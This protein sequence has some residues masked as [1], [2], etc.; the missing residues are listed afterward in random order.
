MSVRR[1]GGR[2]EQF[3][4]PCCCQRFNDEKRSVENRPY[5]SGEHVKRP[6]PDQVIEIVSELGPNG[7]I[8]PIPEIVAK[9][10]QQTGCSRATAEMRRTI[11]TAP[12]LS[13]PRSVAYGAHDPQ[14]P[15]PGATGGK[16]P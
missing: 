8:V 2:R 1:Q 3:C 5:T 15:Q 6:T 14:P 12:V 9:I 10:R 16:P 11:S 13:F 7:E 4:S